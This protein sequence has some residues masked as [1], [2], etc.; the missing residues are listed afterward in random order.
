[1]DLLKED[2]QVSADVWSAPGITELRREGLEVDHWNALHPEETPRK[3]WVTQQLEGQRGP[4]IAATDYIK[5]YADQIRSFV[6]APYHVLGADGYGHSDTRER[7]RDFFEVDA[8][9]ITLT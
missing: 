4:V 8:R 6:P 3:P 9:W 5:A 1:R 2:W 7:L